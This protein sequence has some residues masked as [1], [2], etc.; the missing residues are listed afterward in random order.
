MTLQT[1]QPAGCGQYFTGVF[2]ILLGCTF[3]WAYGD[4]DRN[5][6]TRAFIWVC[7]HSRPPGRFMAWFYFFLLLLV[8]VSTIVGR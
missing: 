8:G 3:L 7:E 5:A 6:I 2:F 4:P 1:T